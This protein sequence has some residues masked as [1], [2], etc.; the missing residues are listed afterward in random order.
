MSKGWFIMVFFAILWLWLATVTLKAGGATVA[1]IFVLIA[2]AIIIFVPL[3]KK[4]FKKPN[5]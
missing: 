4:Y 3:W 5:D 1:N 2:S